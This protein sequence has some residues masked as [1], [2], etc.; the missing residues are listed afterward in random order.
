L[1]GSQAE[2]PETLTFR[3][4]GELGWQ[5]LGMDG[6]GVLRMS[7]PRALVNGL[8]GLAPLDRPS[9]EPLHFHRTLPGYEPTPLHDL[10][11]EAE[12][13]RLG[14]IRLKDES[15]RLGLPAFKILGATWAVER[16]LRQREKVDTLVA[17]SAGN[18]GRAVARAAALRGLQ[19]RIFLPARAS[20]E[21]AALIAGE[22]AEVV[23]VDGSYEEA[24]GAAARAGSE[25]GVALVADVAYGE[26][27]E[28]PAWIV[29]GYA[30]LFAEVV[31]QDPRP[32]DLVLAQIG[33]GS[34]AA[35]AIR[36]AVS[37]VPP[38]L[39]LGVEPNDAACVTASLAADE[40]LTIET[41]GTSMAGL[42]CAQPSAAAW[43][44]MRRHLRGC[45]TVS[46]DETQQV[47]RDLAGH[48][49][50]IGDCGAAPLA[51]LRALLTDP[52][53]RPLRDV[54]DLNETSRVLFI[55]TEGASDPEHYAH[56]L[57]SD[58]IH[59]RG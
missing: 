49:L 9:R 33:V 25:P 35:A 34:F 58:R 20:Q 55:A 28:V 38:A 19:S 39:V 5:D 1:S 3:N 52:E 13:L 27:D 2:L 46:D 24:V 43:P 48:G 12:S 30:T 54:L 22:G 26:G 40:C 59:D 4:G 41:S 47:M 17:A 31:E 7:T 53:C 14:S 57:G 44:L 37:Q 11:A 45:I 32:F 36:F 18:H 21:R 8:W 50:T 51:A 6:E 10:T 23:R 29:D 56:V 42:D 15:R 16:I